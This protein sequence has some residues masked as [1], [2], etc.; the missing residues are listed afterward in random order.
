MPYRDPE[1]RR[2]YQREYRRMRRAGGEL[3]K[4]TL[5]HALGVRT[6]NL[7]RK[8]G[9]LQRLVDAEIVGRD[10]DLVRALPAWSGA[11]EAARQRGAEDQAGEAQRTRHALERAQYAQGS[12][13]PNDIAR[14]KALARAESA[15]SEAQQAYRAA[16]GS[17]R[18]LRSER[19]DAG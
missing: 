12:A 18:N 7:T 14:R 2:A 6:S 19:E 3:H 15:H 4:S 1:K 17:V 16:R 5:A 9:V 8:D 10:G 13:P 11:L